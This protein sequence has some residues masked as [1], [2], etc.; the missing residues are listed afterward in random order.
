[1]RQLRGSNLD[2]WVDSSGESRPF[3]LAYKIEGLSS[4]LASAASNK[5]DPPAEPAD[6]PASGSGPA[7][8]GA[9][10]VGDAPNPATPASGTGDGKKGVTTES[11]E[12]TPGPSGG[13]SGG[14]EDP[15][16][17]DDAP[18]ATPTGTTIPEGNDEPSG[19][20]ADD[21]APEEIPPAWQADQ[22]DA[23]LTK[24]ERERIAS[25]QS[26]WQTRRDELLE[27][28]P[29]ERGDGLWDRLMRI[30]DNVRANHIANQVADLDAAYYATH[31]HYIGDNGEVYAAEVADDG[32]VE[33]HRY[34]AN[35]TLGEAQANERS[36]EP[37]TDPDDPEGKPTGHGLPPGLPKPDGDDIHGATDHPEGDGHD[38]EGEQLTPEGL[39]SNPGMAG[40]TTSPD[41]ID[42]YSDR[43]TYWGD[44]STPVQMDTSVVL[45]SDGGI[46]IE[47][48]VRS[49]TEAGAESMRHT[50]TFDRHQER[51]DASW[52]NQRAIVVDENRTASVTTSSN[53]DG[54]TTSSYRLEDQSTGD[55][56]E[57]GNPEPVDLPENFEEL[58]AL[59]HQMGEMYEGDP[60]IA[61]LYSMGFDPRDPDSKFFIDPT[62]MSRPGDPDA[63][64]AMLRSQAH[65]SQIAPLERAVLDGAAELGSDRDALAQ[66]GDENF[67][68]VREMYEGL[69]FTS[70]DGN[71]E[72]PVRWYDEGTPNNA[73]YDGSRLVFGHRGD[74]PIALSR[75]VL[76]HEFGHHLVRENVDLDYQDQEG[77]INESLA[78][79][80]AAVSDNDWHIGED[81]WEGGGIRDMSRPRTMDDYLDTSSDNGGVHTNSSIPNYAAYLIAQSVGRQEMGELYGAAL[82]DHLVDDA[83]FEDLA[84]ATYRA[85]V[86]L[87]GDGSR[88]VEAVR[89]AWD[90]VLLLNGDDRLW[91]AE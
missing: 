76:V 86:D 26:V 51:V 43:P 49:M 64:W 4:A 47:T 55:V 78:D 77:A 25:E 24:E 42:G 88:E 12:P 85:A 68:E 73:Y 29:D 83:N 84:T 36:F 3:T 46:H 53:A 58:E 16:S 27:R 81:A 67:A 33:L 89:Q 28:M 8:E 65:R 41:K 22:L 62:G 45:A 15:P 87:Y 13:D 19:E 23:A 7:A 35:T 10:S 52:W 50:T 80:F 11:T 40:L 30:P 37:G 72:I 57:Y 9:D 66:E 38:H 60:G 91:T 71:N 31:D 5:P 48:A 6:P 17:V 44:T 2:G 20:G 18:A 63:V 39:S 59:Q 90:G 56:I 75:D 61:D 32:A 54:Q 82:R 14:G 70:E 74:V 34:G 21:P 79:T 1:M 69:G